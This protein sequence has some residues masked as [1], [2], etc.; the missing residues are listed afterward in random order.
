MN[1]YSHFISSDGKHTV[2]LIK[3][4]ESS[5]LYGPIDGQELY[6]HIVILYTLM[7]IN[8]SSTTRIHLQGKN[9]YY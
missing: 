5:S 8:Y 2:Q 7:L 6:V 4:T 1:K 9:K 3:A